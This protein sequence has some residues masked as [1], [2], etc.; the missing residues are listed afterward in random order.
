MTTSSGVRT[1]GII[2]AGGGV[3]VAR[4]ALT[5]S[6]PKRSRMELI[7]TI[8]SMP[9]SA[10]GCSNRARAFFLA[11]ALSFGA[12]PS[13]N[14]TQTMSVPLAKALGNMSGR[15]PGVKIKL[16]RGRIMR[17]VMSASFQVMPI[18]TLGN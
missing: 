9:S 17:V 4:M 8:L 2:K 7:L 1:F 11:S 12:I 3:F 18:R 13:S 5:S 15:K 10:G 16:R 14:S 6:I